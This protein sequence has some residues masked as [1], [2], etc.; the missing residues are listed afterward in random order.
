[1]NKKINWNRD[2]KKRLFYK[3]LCEKQ[4]SILKYLGEWQI[5]VIIIIIVYSKKIKIF[6]FY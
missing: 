1:M 2:C 5:I 6:Y 4:G 3:W